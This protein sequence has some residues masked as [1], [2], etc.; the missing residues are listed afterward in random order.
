MGRRLLIGCALAFTLA[1]CGQPANSRFTDAQID[2]I[3]ADAANGNERSREALEKA[4]ELESRIDELE[5]RH[6]R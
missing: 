6:G 3:R 5:G 1:A 2:A 4:Q